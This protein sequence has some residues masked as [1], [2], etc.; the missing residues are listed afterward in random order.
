MILIKES[1]LPYGT[2]HPGQMI[3]GFAGTGLFARNLQQKTQISLA[4]AHEAGHIL[5]I[6]TKDNEPGISDHHQPPFSDVVNLDQP[7]GNAPIYPG[8]PLSNTS[9]IQITL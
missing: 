4:T 1:G 7:N 2:D 5:Q 3:R 6:S 8:P 9:L